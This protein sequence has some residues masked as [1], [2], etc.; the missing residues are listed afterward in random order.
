MRLPKSLPQMY[1]S[2]SLACTTRIKNSISSMPLPRLRSSKRSAGICEIQNTQ[3]ISAHWI[4][5]ER[6]KK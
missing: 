4:F 5:V 1:C 2:T 3:I 6:S